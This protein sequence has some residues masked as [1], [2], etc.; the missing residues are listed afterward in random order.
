MSEKIVPLQ[1]VRA[2][3]LSE[4]TN[5]TTNAVRMAGVDS[6]LDGVTDIWM[7]RVWTAPGHA[8]GPHHH[9]EAQTAGYVLKGEA[10]LY[11]GP[12][13]KESIDLDEGDFVFV[14]P[15][16]HHIEAN[17]SDEHEL[18]WLTARSP[19]N[20]VINLDETVG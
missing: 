4:E 2:S 3:E 15:Y 12:G 13:Y 17:R 19:D 5:Q 8:S 9:G 6:R 20:I 10:R 7:G 14:P 16:F 18:I 1:V 11:F